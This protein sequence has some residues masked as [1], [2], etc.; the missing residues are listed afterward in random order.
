MVTSEWPYP[1]GKKTTGEATTGT[2]GGEGRQRGGKLGALSQRKKSSA[3]KKKRTGRGT[4]GK[5]WMIFG[6]RGVK[7][8]FREKKKTVQKKTKEVSPPS[9]PFVK[10]SRPGTLGGS[11]VTLSAWNGGGKDK[12][13]VSSN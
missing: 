10:P 6:G 13:Q 4:E 9:Y 11:A 5:G 1:K 3:G 2:K 12:R 8:K 7:S